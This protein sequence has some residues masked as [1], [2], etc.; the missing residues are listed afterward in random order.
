MEEDI[1]V[2]HEYIKNHPCRGFHSVPRHCPIDNSVV[3]YFEDEECFADPL[4]AGVVVYRA[5]RDQ[6]IVGCKIL[7]AK[8][9][10][11]E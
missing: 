9:L 2:L 8:Q 5:Y 1:N 10:M 11:G 4:H 3:V 6:R 7:N